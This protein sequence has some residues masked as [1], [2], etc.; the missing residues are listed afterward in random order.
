MN[1]L[2]SILFWPFSGLVLISI[3]I[4][5][6][7]LGHYWVGRGFGAAVESFSIGFGKPIFEARDKRGTRWRIN[8]MPLGGFVKFVGEIQAPTDKREP[9]AEEPVRLVGKPYTDLGPF[10]RICVSLGGPF[11][12]FVFAVLVFAAMGF[13]FGVPQ[14]R[15]V[16]VQSVLPGTPAEAAGFRAGDIFVEAGGKAV[17]IR[18]DVTRATQLNAGEQVTYK[19]R[20]NGEVITLVATPN[21]TVE[22]NDALDVTEKVGKVG[23]ELVNVNVTLRSLNPIEAV[24]YGFSSTGDAIGATVTVLR[25]LVTGKDGLDKLSGP[26]GIFSLADKVTD[27]HM[28]QPDVPIGKRIGD[29]LISWLQLAALLSIGVGFFNLL[30]IPVLDGGAVVMCLAEAVTG[31]EIPEKVQQV[32]LTIGLA[33]LVSFALLITWQDLTRNLPWLGGS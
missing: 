25:R 5:V 2:I 27:L 31:R 20:R 3:V 16:A 1:D 11:A 8:W 22:K 24:G 6:H 33:C 29:L 9:G 28:K 32:G 26:V 13:A 4:T 19:V 14:A 7:E 21:E 30:P 23:V 10:K 15:E 18:D 17:T 12:N